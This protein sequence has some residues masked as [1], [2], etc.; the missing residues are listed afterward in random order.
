MADRV[1]VTGPT[2][3]IGWHVCEAFRDAGWNV[4]AVVRP[5]S[6]KPLPAGVERVAANLEA[7][8][9]T[10]T[11]GHASA[12][13]HLAGIMRASSIGEYRRVNVEGTREVAEAARALGARMIHVSSL[14]VAGPA[15]ADRPKTEADAP[16][17]ITDYGRSKMESEA[18]VQRTPGL[19]WT[20]IRPAAVYGPRDRQFLPL[21]QAARRGL[22]LRPSNADSFSLTV[23]HGAD[24]ARGIEMACRR[25]DVDG[26][27]L[28]IGHPT[29]VSLDRVLRTLALIVD[30][31]YRPLPVPFALARVAAW[32]GIAGMRPERLIEM[33]SPGFVCSV[34]RAERCL[35][36][37]AQIDLADGFRSTAAWYVENRWLS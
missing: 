15:P 27:T 22:F 36:F 25:E 37:R 9:L 30:R 33:K 12:I 4:V 31:P 34:A 19:R 16:A 8:A 28:F 11:F 10:R 26:E 6:R 20:T 5:E 24:V 2:G 1:A 13:V 18:I 17:P 23:V 29:P 21:F 3:F 14:T 7:A 32:L 35:G